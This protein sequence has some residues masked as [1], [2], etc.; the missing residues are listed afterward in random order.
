M[1]NVRI[2]KIEL[3]CEGG[4]VEEINRIDETE[5]NEFRRVEG[6]RVDLS[7]CEVVSPANMSAKVSYLNSIAKQRT[8]KGKWADIPISPGDEVGGIVYE[9]VERSDPIDVG[10]IS[11]RSELNQIYRARIRRA[12]RE[13]SSLRGSTPEANRKR[14]D[15]LRVIE[16]TAAKI[17]GG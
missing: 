8:S 7:Q 15:L 2:G 1:P 14:E 12:N 6:T 4:G 16:E 13:L 9:D 5:P 3:S 10:S 11:D 17:S